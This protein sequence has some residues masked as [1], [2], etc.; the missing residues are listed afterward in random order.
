MYGGLGGVGKVNLNGLR[1]QLA[2]PHPGSP[3]HRDGDSSTTTSPLSSSSP[4]NIAAICEFQ[5][6]FS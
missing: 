2:Q 6:P 3:L 4:L 5:C 1:S